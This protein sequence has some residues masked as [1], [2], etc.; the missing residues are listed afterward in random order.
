[1]RNIIALAGSNGL[2]GKEI[3]NIF[4]TNNIKHI[5]FNKPTCDITNENDLLNFFNFNRNIKIFI[6]CAAYT[7]V[8]KAEFEEKEKCENVNGHSLR[9]LSKLCSDN[10]VHLM[11]FST[12][13]VF[14]GTKGF[15]YEEDDDPNPINIYGKS[16]LLGEKII[17]D[18]MENYSI[19]RLQWMY[20]HNSK[21][22]F[23]KILNHARKN[24]GINLV[25]DEFG[26][27]CSAK[28]VAETV[29][30]ILECGVSNFKGNIFHLTHDNFCSRYE[31]GFSF[32]ANFDNFAVYPILS[33]DISG[34]PR[35]KYGALSNKKLTVLL[36]KSLGTWQD[37][38]QKYVKEMKN[39]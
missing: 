21:N 27:P 10:G 15:P 4:I 30:D 24:R 19:F 33:S 28:F 12:D 3:E 37:D 25:V 36:G 23:S 11:H 32:L 22:F 29:V 18:N 5:K 9:Y 38:L 39:A 16:K 34:V 17:T 6:N 8:P 31:C 26:S 1:M 7:D 2:L 13:F 35:P 20:G 14:D